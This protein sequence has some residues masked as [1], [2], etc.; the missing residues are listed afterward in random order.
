MT[1][2]S[3][4][5]E[6][7]WSLDL[8]PHLFIN[9]GDSNEVKWAKSKLQALMAFRYGA[10]VDMRP[11]TIT[12]PNDAHWFAIIDVIKRGGIHGRINEIG[13]EFRFEFT[14]IIRTFTSRETCA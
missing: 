2:P 9:N 13:S 4:N 11:L 10:D 8:Y 5:P 3:G 1:D 12:C 7:Q 14:D 6:T